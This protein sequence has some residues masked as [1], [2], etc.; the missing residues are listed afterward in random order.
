MSES[1]YISHQ[2]ERIDYG[3]CAKHE[4]ALF[5]VAHT[6]SIEQ[7]WQQRLPTHTLMQT[8][9]WL[10]ARLALALAPHASTIWIATGPGNNGGD[11]LEAAMHLK[12]WGKHVVVTSTTR[13]QDLPSDAQHSYQN[14]VR[15]GVTFANKAPASFELAVDAMLGI[16]ATRSLEGVMLEWWEQMQAAV[17][18]LLCLDIPS[19]LDAD[20]G[21]WRNKPAQR[22][23]NCHT[24]SFLTLKP[25]L[26]TGDGRDACGTVWWA[27]L[28]KPDEAPPHPQAY[29]QTQSKR[30]LRA[31][32]TLNTHKGQF[33]DVVVIGGAKGMEGAAIL[34]SVAALHAGAGRVFA[35]II[36]SAAHSSVMAAHPAL[37]VRA[38][39]DLIRHVSQVN[40]S[41]TVCG[42]GGD[43]AV[44]SWL[45]QILSQS[46]RLVLDA[47]A[48]N[49]IAQ[50]DHLLALLRQRHARDWSTILTPHPLE[51]ARLLRSTTA[52][53]QANR[54]KSAQQ[55]AEQTQSIVVLKGSG[56]V[57]SAHG[58]VPIINPTGNDRLST[59][60]SGD[61]LAGLIGARLAQRLPAWQ[62]A[63]ESV[64][65]HGQLA[66]DWPPQASAPDA[67]DL[68]LGLMR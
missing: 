16:G 66:D 29:L 68:A 42:C 21:Q 1:A 6:R 57:I 23:A 24:L 47:D 7:Y 59:A 34:A 38:P 32:I 31:P 56:S 11:G 54:L 63:C 55:L 53:V 30:S 36:D 49:A 28:V 67:L 17:C 51:A 52:Q 60:G 39:G 65:Q 27:P 46:P 10:S 22:N 45:P 61:V 64:W 12:Q 14:A 40:A 8:A 13:P 37:M 15:A 44:T 18:P 62:A 2:I 41:A 19:G 33:G 20:T 25:G 50:D 35:G 4:W 26:W 5:D 58:Q 43:Q 48:L 9:G 3:V